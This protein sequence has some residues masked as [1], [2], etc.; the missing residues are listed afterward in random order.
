MLLA[1]FRSIALPMLIPTISIV[2]VLRT[3]EAFKV[4]DLIY[5][6]TRGGPAGGTTTI[7][8]YAYT[9]A[10]S[11]QNFGLGSALSVLI[12]L[13]ILVLTTIYL[14]LLRRSEMSLL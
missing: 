8:F 7:S 2:L 12:L 14:R 10:F 4:F 5:A 13:V 9:T 3:I 11:D 1:I 6:M